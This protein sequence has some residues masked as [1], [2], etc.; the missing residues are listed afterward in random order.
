MKI[1]PYRKDGGRIKN[2]TLS[3][4]RVGCKKARAGVLVSPGH[5]VLGAS[6]LSSRLLLPE[7]ERVWD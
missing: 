4:K 5:A 7:R 2:D 1:I 6:G 3:G